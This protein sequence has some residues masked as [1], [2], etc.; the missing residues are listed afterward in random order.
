MSTQIVN[1]DPYLRTSWHF[2]PDAQLMVELTRSFNEV[3]IVTNMRTIGTY[4]LGLYSITGEQW[5]LGG[6]NQQQQ[7]IRMVLQFTNTN[8]IN[9][10]VMVTDPNQFINCYGAFTDGTNSYGLIF[11]SSVAIAGQIS[12]YITAT[13]VVFVVGA[14]APALVNGRIV[15]QWLSN[16]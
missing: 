3:A 1:V 5:F 6:S 16:A 15:L 14:G 8:S 9:H 4:A 11:G 10:N 13:Q 7:S 2:T 12:F